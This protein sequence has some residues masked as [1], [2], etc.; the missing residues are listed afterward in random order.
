MVT[1][2]TAIFSRSLEKFHDNG[3]KDYFSSNDSEEDNNDLIGN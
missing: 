1:P 2:M 3:E